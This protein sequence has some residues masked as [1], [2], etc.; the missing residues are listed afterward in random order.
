MSEI[1]PEQPSY[2]NQNVPK[3]GIF[4]VECLLQNCKN[5]RQAKRLSVRFHL[6]SVAVVMLLLQFKIVS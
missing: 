4:G 2:K 3:V 6:K 5:D 1:D